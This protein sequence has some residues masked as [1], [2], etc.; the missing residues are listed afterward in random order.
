M[1]VWITPLLRVKSSSGVGALRL[2][3]HPKSF[4][5][6]AECW[7]MAA[8]VVEAAVRLGMRTFAKM[9]TLWWFNVARWKMDEN[10]PRKD[11]LATLDTLVFSIATWHY[12]RINHHRLSIWF[13]HETYRSIYAWINSEQL[14]PTPT[15]ILDELWKIMPRNLR[16]G[17]GKQKLML[18]W[19]VPNCDF[20]FPRTRQSLVV[21]SEIPHNKLSN[22]KQK[23]FQSPFTFHTNWKL[24][25]SRGVCWLELSIN[26]SLHIFVIQPN[27]VVP[28]CGSGLR[29]GC[30]R[31]PP[32]KSFEGRHHGQCMARWS[33]HRQ[34]VKIID[35]ERVGK[36]WKYADNIWI[37]M[38]NILRY[39]EN[40]WI[41][42]DMICVEICLYIYGNMWDYRKGFVFWC[43]NAFPRLHMAEAGKH[44]I[45]LGFLV[46]E[47]IDASRKATI[48]LFRWF[49]W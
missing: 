39:V 9:D 47:S 44:T 40:I 11:D 17:V 46:I 36:C 2:A 14:R 23:S 5:S 25:K 32:L 34:E 29:R 37:Y 41:W 27:N 35:G 38:E 48:E 30:C 13:L 21:G 26:P 33:W 12:Q 15:C 3:G 4:C 43:R 24:Y 49:V 16:W 10:D 42:L 28:T 20:L 31:S 1:C 19:L 6:A 8:E 18:C 22:Q 7:R 45:Y